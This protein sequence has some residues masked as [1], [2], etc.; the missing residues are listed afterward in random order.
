MGFLP[1]GNRHDHWW[2]FCAACRDLLAGTGLPTRIT[3]AEHRFRDLLRNGAARIAGEEVSLQGLTDHQ[4]A[5]LE[6]F[7]AIFF[8]ELE[9]FAPDE[10]FPAFHRELERRRGR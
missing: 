1:N 3:H 8:R 6:E 5:A 10:L 4:W 9:S 7:A 2:R